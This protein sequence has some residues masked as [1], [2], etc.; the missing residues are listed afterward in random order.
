MGLLRLSVR[1]PLA[2][3]EATLTAVTVTLWAAGMAEG[4]VYNP[5]PEIVPVAPAPPVM[6]FTCHKTAVLA[7]PVT[8][9]LNWVVELSRV[10]EAPETLTLI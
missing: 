4:A 10:E 7:V 2:L 6:P 5:L 1:L 8:V 3:A 9:A